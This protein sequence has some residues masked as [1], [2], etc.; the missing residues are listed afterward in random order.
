[1]RSIAL[2]L[3]MLA[4]AWTPEAEGGRPLFRWLGEDGTVHFADTPG[5]PD[6]EQ[7][8][9]GG[10]LS[11]VETVPVKPHAMSPPVARE[12]RWQEQGKREADRAF[13]AEAARHEA[14]CATLREQLAGVEGRRASGRA[15]DRRRARIN[16]LEDRIFRLCR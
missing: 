6:A 1:M 7:V 4:V 13:A 5:R 3:A 9:P 14:Q 12:L 11:I 10:R 15:A 8:E 16:E 2:W